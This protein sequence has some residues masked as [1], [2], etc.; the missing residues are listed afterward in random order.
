VA[1]TGHLEQGHGT[2][3]VLHVGRMHQQFEC[4]AIGVDHGVA[5]APFTFLP[6][7]KPR[8]PPASVVFTLAIDHRY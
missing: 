7:S 8:G 2:I 4:P 3:A 6:A 5:L 1:A